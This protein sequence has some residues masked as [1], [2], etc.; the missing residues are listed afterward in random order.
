MMRR[1]YE[2]QRLQEVLAEV[3]GPCQFFQE[4]IIDHESESF[5]FFVALITMHKLVSTRRSTSAWPFLFFEAFYLLLKFCCL[6][7][8][9]IKFDS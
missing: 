5:V 3:Q 6:I 9:Y 4:S 7:P 2:A 8:R 1:A